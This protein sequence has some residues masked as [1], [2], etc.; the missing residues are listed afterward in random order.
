MKNHRLKSEEREESFDK[1]DM[2]I[3]RLLVNDSRQ[4]LQEIGS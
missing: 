2:A 3:L 4:T 1:T